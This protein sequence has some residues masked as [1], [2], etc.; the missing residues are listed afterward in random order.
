MDNYSLLLAQFI[1]FCIGF[2]NMTGLDFSLPLTVHRITA[3]DSQ[4]SLLPG[5]SGYL[6][7]GMELHRGFVV[8]YVWI[9]VVAIIY[10]GAVLIGIVLMLCCL[11]CLKQNNSGANA[12]RLT[13]E[14]EAAILADDLPEEVDLGFRKSKLRLETDSK[15][16]T[17]PKERKELEEKRRESSENELAASPSLPLPV[18]R[19][20]NADLSPPPL[21][22]DALGLR[23][24]SSVKKHV[25]FSFKPKDADESA[26]VAWNPSLR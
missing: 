10:F 14:A 20:C 5:Y 15:S 4:D 17:K 12:S 6:G 22:R 3:G 13:E 16:S 19:H 23:L 18:M 11:C 8:R 1:C 2:T 24:S 25:R 9:A 7:E 21:K 26:V